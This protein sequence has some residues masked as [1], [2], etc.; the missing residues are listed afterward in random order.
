MKFGFAI[1]L[2]IALWW[3]QNDIFSGWAE[4][5][6]IV[7]FFWLLVQGL[8]LLDF[9]HDVH[10]ILMAPAAEGEEESSVPY[11]VYMAL[12]AG[13]LGAAVVG[14]VFLFKDY[15]GCDLGMFFIILTLIMGV[16]TTAI[17]L[18]D[19]VG[20]GLLTPCL[21]FAY[22][23]FMC[24]YALLSS[25]EHSCNPT[26]D[27]VNGA[28]DGGVIVI[29]AIT[30]TVL[31]YCVANGTTILNIFNP[32]GEGVMMSYQH[33]STKRTELHDVVTGGSGNNIPLLSQSSASYQHGSPH[34]S[35]AVEEGEGGEKEVAKEEVKSS[36]TAARACALPSAAVEEGEG[37][38]KEVAK[39]EVKSSG[40]AHER[41]L[42]HVIMMLVCCYGSMILTNW[43]KT[44]GATAEGSGSSAA[45]SSESMWLKIVSQWIFLILYL[46]VLQVAYNNNTP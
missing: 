20:K 6:R 42:Y 41:V 16:L 37:G 30:L 44:N 4:F 13:G 34:R 24:W 23:V 35:A 12:S 14:L 33:D 2:F 7:S 45:T 31:L 1:G 32:E 43:G 26:A 40:T 38:E 21:M 9:C 5:A 22:S 46:R 18:L 3:I 17:S 29:G 36:G 19:S 25:P 10:D 11:I 39:E 15:A 27:R 8:L 28:Q